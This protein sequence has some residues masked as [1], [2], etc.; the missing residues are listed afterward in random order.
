MVVVSVLLKWKQ[1]LFLLSHNLLLVC[2]II[3]YLGRYV[4]DWLVSE[5]LLLYFKV[6]YF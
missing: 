6:L 3:S 4:G 2:H 5:F 1:L